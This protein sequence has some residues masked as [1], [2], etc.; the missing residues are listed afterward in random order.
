M[1]WD[2]GEVISEKST[3]VRYAGKKLEPMTQY[4]WTVEVVDNHGCRAET[5]GVFETADASYY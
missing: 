3:F 5:S 2:S 4:R 1:F